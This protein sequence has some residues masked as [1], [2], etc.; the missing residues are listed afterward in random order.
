MLLSI[1]LKI[2]KKEYIVIQWEDIVS[3][4]TTSS[5]KLPQ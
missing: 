3:F 2:N 5:N 1:K 4:N